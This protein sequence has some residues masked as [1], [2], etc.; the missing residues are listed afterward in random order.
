[1][2]KTGVIFLSLFLAVILI[3]SSVVMAVAQDRSA[4][5]EFNASQSQSMTTECTTG[6]YGQSSTCKTTGSQSQSI[7]GRQI[8]YTQPQVAGVRTHTPVNTALDTQA[9]MMLMGTGLTGIAAFAG[10]L[11]LK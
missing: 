8:V 9:M 7:S 3:G 2:T 4:E 11:K 5:Q 1:M 10:Y 6:A